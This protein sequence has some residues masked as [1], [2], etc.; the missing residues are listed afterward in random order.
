MSEEGN[1]NIGLKVGLGIAIALF[2][3]TA[4]YTTTL[5]KSKKKN[6]R[7]LVQEKQDVLKELNAISE[8]YDV[9]MSENDVVNQDLVEAKERINGLID[10]LQMSETN[11]RSL[12]KYKNRYLKVKNEM[13]S[14]L[15]ENDK[16]KVENQLLATSLDS[17]KNRLQLT[18]TFSDSLLIQNSQLANVVETASALATTNLKGYGVIERTSGKLVPTERAKRSDK[19]R[20]CY[21]VAKNR[22]AES[23]D[24]K[25]YV[26]VV[27]PSNK[28]LGKNA[29]MDFGDETLNYSL[30]SKFNYENK[31]LNICEFITKSDKKEKFEAGRYKVNIYNTEEL[32]SSAEFQL[33]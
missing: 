24:K 8:Q 26:Q 21:T 16:L 13:K 12:W 4:I 25:L 23:G 6:E 1:K 2:I 3:G 20:V 30:E 33:K 11:V 32:I 17:T 15:A 10:S 14:L 5:Y 22:L 31:N 28:V 19:I 29:Q 27:S 7:I 18:T 9:A